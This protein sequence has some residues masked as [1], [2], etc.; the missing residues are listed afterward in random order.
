MYG[1]KFIDGRYHCC[2]DCSG[3]CIRC[4]LLW[5]TEWFG[6]GVD[7]YLWIGGTKTGMVAKD[8]KDGG[9]RC[10]WSNGTGSWFGSSRRIDNH[11]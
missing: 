8:A 10:F 1:G 11:L 3:R 6:H 9:D 4:Y 2:R 7:L 5:C